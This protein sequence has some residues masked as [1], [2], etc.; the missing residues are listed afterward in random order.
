M[1][2]SFLNLCLL[3][4][5]PCVCFIN[6]LVRVTFGCKLD[7]RASYQCYEKASYRYFLLTTFLIIAE[8]NGH[9]GS[10]YVSCNNILL[11][12]QKS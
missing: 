11:F 9:S 12:H 2:S 5:Y 10:L 8:K 7:T 3:P 6:E 1:Q 4:P